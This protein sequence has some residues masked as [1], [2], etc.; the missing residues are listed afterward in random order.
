MTPKD[1]HKIV[2]Q[3]GSDHLGVFGGERHGGVNLQQI[4]DEITP[5]LYY[6]HIATG[7]KIKNYLEIGAASGGLTYLVNEIF[8]PEVIILV[9]D[10]KHGKSKW[11][12]G[13]LKDVKREEIIGDSQSDKIIQAVKNYCI[14]FD[15]VVVDADHRYM[16]VYNDINNYK[17]VCQDFL[18][19]HDTVACKGVKKAFEE[20]KEDYSFEFMEEFIS[21]SNLNPLGI[22]LFRRRMWNFPPKS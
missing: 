15:L 16:G 18:M 6:L 5:C 10:N 3:G 2:L 19:V 11:R 20:F 1:I 12:K 13:I 22:G 9:D 17:H 14:L 21:E 4:P 8:S 7:G